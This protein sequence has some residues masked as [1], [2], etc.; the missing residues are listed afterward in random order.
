MEEL[1][2]GALVKAVELS[3]AVAVLIWQAW[4]SDQR[5]QECIAKLFAHLDKEH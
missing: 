4:R 5:A 2:L 1:L 3:P